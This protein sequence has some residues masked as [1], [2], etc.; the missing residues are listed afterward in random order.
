MM[1]IPILRLDCLSTN[2][3]GHNDISLQSHSQAVF[4]P[5]RLQIHLF[6]SICACVHCKIY[7]KCITSLYALL[8]AGH[9]LSFIILRV[10]TVP[11]HVQADDQR[12]YDAVGNCSA[13]S[14]DSLHA[15]H[16]QG[17]F[18][19]SGRRMASIQSMRK[20][21]E[22][23]A[24]CASTLHV[25]QTSRSQFWPM[26]KKIRTDHKGDGIVEWSHC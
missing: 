25:A 14:S 20:L 16:R 11:Q 15:L 2:V 18:V 21:S 24:S 13:Y 17:S 5:D 1:A 26:S 19:E 22:R 9:A 8:L 23:W 12:C 6:R 4:F 3:K 7:H 10:V